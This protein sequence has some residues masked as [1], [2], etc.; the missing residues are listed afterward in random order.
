MSVNFESLKVKFIEKFPS[1]QFN[2]KDDGKS[3]VYAAP[4]GITDN[5][6]IHYELIQR[7]SLFFVEFHI[8]GNEYPDYIDRAHDCFGG[9]ANLRNYCFFTYY[10]SKYWQTRTPV[11]SEDDLG[12]DI[13]KLINVVAPI[14]S[15]EVSMTK[16]LGQPDGK[17]LHGGYMTCT[18]REIH[19]MLTEKILVIPDIQRGKVWNVAR[20]ATLWDSI[21]R[22]FP[23]GTFSVQENNNKLELLDGQQ[24]STAICLGF[25]TF[26][27]ADG[28]KKAPILWIDLDKDN[29][30]LKRGE[31]KFS[32]H[33]TTCSQPWGYH[34][35][36]DEMKNSLLSAEEKREAAKGI[37]GHDDNA[38]K[39]YPYELT[40][41]IANQPIPFSLLTS[42]IKTPSPLK[43]WENFKNWGKQYWPGFEKMKDWVPD[44]NYWEKIVNTVE[45]LD[46]YGILLTDASIVTAEDLALF[47]TRIGRGGVVPDDEELAY[48]VLK[49]KLGNGFRKKI[50]EIAQKGMASSARIAHLA[51]RCF[52]SA[53]KEF[54]SGSILELV[55]R[56]VLGDN[57]PINL[58]NF[59]VFMDKEFPEL[60]KR[61]DKALN[62]DSPRSGFTHWHRSRYCT[63]ANGDLYLFLLL[64]ARDMEEAELQ[65]ALGM[66]EY[67]HCFAG[68]IRRVLRTIRSQEG[69]YQGFRDALKDCYRSNPVLPVPIAPCTFD[70]VD[71]IDKLKDWWVKPENHF[72]LDLLKKGYGNPRAY[73]ILLF[74]CRESIKN[75]KYDSY[76][77]E[78]A[79][80]SCPWDYDHILPQNWFN[81][82]KGMDGTALCFELKNSI[83]N[84]APLP[85]SLNRALHDNERGEFYPGLEGDSDCQKK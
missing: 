71:S 47:F 80:D 42:W 56:I 36:S 68:D 76:L 28:N 5:D 21:M 59:V 25:G 67:I 74:A 16:A 24:R 45:R 39:P 54:Y 3:W 58:Q 19:D 64:T 81:K 15:Q 34:I 82:I 29:S 26:P 11:F 65:T 55:N 32:F 43:T 18:P 10:S 33:I 7:G 44:E 8:E 62:L 85:F 78:W 77:E 66:A 35:L 72:S 37:N 38:G 53:E 46:S 51:L 30:D 83:G 17:H 52:A 2:F 50:E 22:R 75:I 57:T 9:D 61:I 6:S 31:K 48:S 79:D 27:P 69:L 14:F 23:I 63:Y 73:S 40:P 12:K 20:S 70:D 4:E 49:S 60:V 84:L 1:D 41:L 13:D